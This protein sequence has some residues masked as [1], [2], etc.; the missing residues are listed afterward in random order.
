MIGYQKGGYQQAP[1]YYGGTQQQ[2]C[3]CVYMCACVVC[4]VCG[5]VEVRSPT[6]RNVG[7]SQCASWC[8]K[9]NTIN[10]PIAP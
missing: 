8:Y 4:W 3:N 9:L 5:G 7:Y 1:P 2:V 6:L 10:W